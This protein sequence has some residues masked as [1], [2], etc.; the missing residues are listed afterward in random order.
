MYSSIQ[1][2]HDDLKAKKVSSKE[3]IQNYITKIEESDSKLNCFITKTFDQ[4]LKQAEV[5]DQKISKGE[6]LGL[7]E[8]A[9]FSIKDMFCTKGVRTTAGSRMLENFIPPYSSTVN[10]RLDAAGAIM[11]GKVNQDEFAMGSS[12][13]TSYFGPSFNPWDVSKVPGGSSGASAASVAARM[14]LCSMGTDT[15]GS[16][17]QPAHFCGTVGFKPT[18]GRVSRYGVVAFASSLDQAGP[19]SLRVEDAFRVVQS[20]SGKDMMDNTSSDKAVPDWVS[21]AKSFNGSLKGK[22]VGFIKE[23]AETDVDPEIK[24]AFEKSLKVLKDAGAEVKEV[25]IPLIKHGVSVYYLVAT[26]EA[27]SNLSRYDGVRYGFRAEVEDAAKGMSLDDFYA[28]TRSQGFGEEVKRRILLGNF[29][30]SSGYYDAYY[31][32][33]CQVRRMIKSEYETAFKDVDFILSPVSAT[34]AFGVNERV[35]DPLKMF[36]NDFFTVSVNLAGLPGI[37]VPVMKASNGL[38]CGVQLIANQYDESHL[39]QGALTLE[40]EFKFYEEVPSV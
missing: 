27:A 20:I 23:Y 13:E 17:R 39:L 18:Y 26:S 30:L 7:L 40:N 4:A 32:K 19:L 16:I 3:V 8:G 22:R 11:L 21:E 24:E 2:L 33:S 29:A 10:K 6:E 38:P 12:N 14:S 9:P 36:L 1:N 37:T 5:V 31:N 25:S 35:Q 28:K 34:Q 15:G